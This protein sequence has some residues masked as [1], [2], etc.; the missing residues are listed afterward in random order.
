[1]LRINQQSI[2][3]G[4]EEESKAFVKRLLAEGTPVFPVGKSPTYSSY[5]SMLE[6]CRVPTASGFHDYGG[7]G[8]K[9]CERW[10]K[11]FF[12]FLFDMGFRL[13]NSVIERKDVNGN[14]EPSNC[15]WAPKSHMARNTRRTT[16]AWIEGETSHEHRLRTRRL[17]RSKHKEPWRMVHRN[18]LKR[19]YYNRNKMIVLSMLILS[20]RHRGKTTNISR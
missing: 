8:I 7:R 20:L 13:E 9:V 18:T 15:I 16:V 3:D 6:R 14:Y 2:L 19:G 5:K 10:K 1:M 17:Y 12:N 4:A 11:S